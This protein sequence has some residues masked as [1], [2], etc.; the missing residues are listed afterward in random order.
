M[1]WRG[2]VARGV[3]MEWDKAVATP[4]RRWALRFLAA[5]LTGLY[6]WATGY[7]QG[8]TRAQEAGQ[9]ALSRLQSQFDR[10]RRQQTERENA[11]LRQWSDRYQRQVTAAH[12]AEVSHVGQIARIESQ[13]RQLK[14]TL[15]GQQTDK[16]HPPECVFSRDFVRRYNA[17]LGDDAGDTDSAATPAARAVAASRQAEA[18]D[19]GLRDSG[20]SRR[21]LLANIADNARQCR[22]WRSQ[23]NGL[24][25]EREALQK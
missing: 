4:W 1:T 22:V 16:P 12:Q 6:L 14:E 7:N 21:D 18:P 2:G 5:I 23:I 3:R 11:A 15:N 24:L 8:V 10:Y 25:D 9:A 19:A 17:A 20:V 13:Y